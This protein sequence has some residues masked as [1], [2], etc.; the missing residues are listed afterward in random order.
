M[1]FD[2]LVKSATERNRAFFDKLGLPSAQQV[3]GAE[4]MR[5]V[6]LE[7]VL[8]F[9]VTLPPVDEQRRVVGRLEGIAESCEC[10]QRSLEMLGAL[11]SS[12]LKSLIQQP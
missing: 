10:R 2:R 9:E 11:E 5:G 1:S 12:S 6:H 7:A 8:A 4:L 3:V